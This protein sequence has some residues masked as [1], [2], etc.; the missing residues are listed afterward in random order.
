MINL[1]LKFISLEYI[2]V[3]E[4]TGELDQ[5]G[6]NLRDQISKKE[7]YLAPIEKSLKKFE[8]KIEGERKNLKEVHEKITEAEEQLSVAMSG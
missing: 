1:T 4:E 7:K 8:E 2:L 3:E 6:K 5:A